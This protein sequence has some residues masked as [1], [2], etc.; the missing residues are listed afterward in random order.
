MSTPA[1]MFSQKYPAFKGKLITNLWENE[2]AV[3]L[4]KIMSAPDEVHH[5][6]ALA[7]SHRMFLLEDAAIVL[8]EDPCKESEDLLQHAKDHLK[9]AE[10]LV[11]D[12]EELAEIMGR[13]SAIRDH[14]LY[15]RGPA[16]KA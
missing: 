4:E 11:E 5:A 7:A 1:E 9:K 16:L 14:A 6:L 12:W 3:I 10:E 2:V 13:P 8:R 15:L